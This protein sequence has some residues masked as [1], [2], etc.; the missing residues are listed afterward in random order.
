[1]TNKREQILHLEDVYKSYGS[2]R[3]LNDIDLKVTKGEFICVVGPSG[4][5]KSTLLRLVTGQEHA[6]DA[7]Y[8]KFKGK[9]IQDPDV[10]RGIV[11]QKY[12]LYPNMT[13]LQNVILGKRLKRGFFGFF[14]KDAEYKK[15]VEEATVILERMSLGKDL[16]KYPHELSGGMRQR[17]A[18]AQSLIMKPEIL[19]MDEPFGALDPG[20]REDMQMLLT[21]IW[22]EHNLTIFFVT[23]DLEE[24]LYLGSRLIVVSQFYTNGNPEVTKHSGAKIVVDRDISEFSHNI[25]VKE[26]PEFNK[27]LREVRKEGFDPEYIQHLKEFNLSHPDSFRTLSK[28]DGGE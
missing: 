21:E 16:D 10:S 11:Y 24:A 14:K 28:E 5:G 25:K 12:G 17:V 9:T 15:A 1:M 23:H 7:K 4:C 20:T 26:T 8:I 18:I 6:S 27:A 13:V 2:K 19:L 3:I 22:Q